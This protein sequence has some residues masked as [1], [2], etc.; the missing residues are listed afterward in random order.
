MFKSRVGISLAVLTGLLT[1]SGVASADEG[2]RSVVYSTPMS[3]SEAGMYNGSHCTTVM[4][5]ETSQGYVAKHRECRV[6]YYGK[7]HR[8][9]CHIVKGKNHHGVYV[10]KHKVCYSSYIR[11]A[12]YEGYY[13]CSKYVLSINPIH[14]D[15]QCSSWDYHP[16]SFSRVVY[17][18]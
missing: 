14:T 18:R 4:G 13:V 9:G 11:A 3:S 7:H 6:A 12:W 15:R 8:S 5:R 16:A 10:A 17:Y 1:I 2:Y